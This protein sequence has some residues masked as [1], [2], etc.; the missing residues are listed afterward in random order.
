M[1]Q[2]HINLLFKCKPKILSERT[3][4]LGLY[5]SSGISNFKSPAKNIFSKNLVKTHLCALCTV[6]RALHLMIILLRMSGI[7]SWPPDFVNSL[8]YLLPSSENVG[9]NVSSIKVIRPYFITLMRCTIG[10][11][12]P[13]NVLPFYVTTETGA[14]ECPGFATLSTLLMDLIWKL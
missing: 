11:S 3:C 10:C 14:A 2:L 5:E 12:T 8:L 9:N 4:F 7:I 6:L 1:S 13:N